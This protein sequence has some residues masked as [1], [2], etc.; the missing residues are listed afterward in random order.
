[1]SLKEM[2]ITS[3]DST[4]QNV[5]Y[6]IHICEEIHFIFQGNFKKAK[7][8]YKFIYGETMILIY[9]GIIAARQC[10]RVLSS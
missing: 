4:L 7:I 5:I 2:R 6:K 9:F 1:M 10:D 8:R 3:S